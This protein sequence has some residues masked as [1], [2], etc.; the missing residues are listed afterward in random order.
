MRSRIFHLSIFLISLYLGCLGSSSLAKETTDS[1]A[2]PPPESF[3]VREEDDPTSGASESGPAKPN[4]SKP[5]KPSD[6]LN[7]VDV[8]SEEPLFDPLPDPDF[9]GRK[10]TEVQPES[11]QV[12]RFVRPPKLRP[13]CAFGHDLR[14]TISDA[15]VPVKLDNILYPD[16]LGRH[17]Y[18]SKGVQT[19]MNGLIYTCRGGVIDLAHMRDYADWTAY[20][21]ERIRIV[22]GSGAAIPIPKEAAERTIVLR[23][24][25]TELDEEEKDELARRL[26]VRISFQLSLWHEIVT[27]YDYRSVSLF[28]ER[29][30]SFSPEDLY[31][32]LLGA[33]IG[34]EALKSAE[35]YNEAM[36]RLLAE[37][38]H[39][40][41]PL[42]NNQTKRTMDAVDGIWWDRTK[43]MPDMHMVTRRNLDISDRIVP[44]L[45]S[46]N[47]SPYCKGR[48]DKPYTLKVPTI[49]PKGLI[50][51]DLYELRF[52]V[53]HKKV[54]DF[55]LPDREREWISED[56]FPRIVE[57][58]RKDVR[59]LFGPF[60]D[61]SGMDIYDLEVQPRVSGEYDPKM[62]C[63]TTDKDCSLTRN[64]ELNGIRIGKLYFAGGNFPGVLMGATLID[65]I[66]PGGLFS[67]LTLNSSV[68][69]QDGSYGLHVKAV[70]SPALFFCSMEV[71]DGSGRTNIDYPFVNP[72]EVKCTPRSYWGI[73]L[74][75]LDVIYI[76]G[77]DSYGIRPIEFGV[78]LNA[79]GN[80]HTLGFL[81][82]RLLLTLGI[83]PELLEVNQEDKIQSVTSFFSGVYV[84][85]FEKNKG[86]FRLFGTFRDQLTAP[87]RFNV[88][89]GTRI[90][91]NHLWSR[92]DLRSGREALHSIVSIG[93]E[94]A[95]TYW[96]RKYPSLPANLSLVSIPY[97][98][99]YLPN[100][101]HISGQLLFFVETTIPK[102]GMF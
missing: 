71:G 75:L 69:F 88:E 89:G 76:S 28:S 38:V 3:E 17:G 79:L 16:R 50:L 70:S 78:V 11:G 49:G 18:E 61:K 77:S 52:I 10:I 39:R 65:G 4:G 86:T 63:G 81:K 46:D 82:R 56:D 40:L 73:K 85:N 58:I 35:P 97:G 66:T 45:V 8:S 13:C 5:S 95:V 43:S 94:A 64:E 93:V 27:W 84:R 33:I 36:N 55:I 91:Y 99:D 48:S 32:N 62:P 15:T 44:W 60:G 2:S 19:E 23:P 87:K 24:V 96:F 92:R 26:A 21:Y 22:L 7:R 102:L 34:A 67:I 83:A 12:L 59:E 42:P 74:D 6:P 90:Q 57:N 1:A 37:A 20:L 41:A 31:S 9:Y 101:W 54:P 100:D 14:T 51:K 25:S 30:S 53:L 68:S 47:Y 72:F 98:K 80:G 29:V